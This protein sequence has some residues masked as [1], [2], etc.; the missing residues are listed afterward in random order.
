MKRVRAGLALGLLLA[1]CARVSDDGDLRA[2]A[3]MILAAAEEHPHGVSLADVFGPS[4]TPEPLP[5]SVRVWRRGLDGSRSSCEGRV[6]RLELEEYLRGVLPNEWMAGWEPAALEAGAIAARTYAAFWVAAGGRYTCADVDDTTWTQV[7]RDR[8]DPRTDAAIERTV[9][10]VIVRD[11]SLVMAEYSAENGSPTRY[12]VEDPICQGRRTKGHGRG[13]CQWGTHRWARRGRDAAW[14]V[15]HYYPGARIAWADD[16]LVD[17]VELT[18]TS[19]ERFALELWATNP[20]PEAW[21]PGFLAVRTGPTPFADA[22]WPSPESPAIWE[23]EVPP[24]ETARVRWWMRA[25]EVTEPTLWAEYFWLE[26]PPDRPGTA[27]SWRIT[28]LPDEPA[29]P[30]AA[31]PPEHR[32]RALAATAVVAIALAGGVALAARRSR[33]R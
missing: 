23:A 16:A 8:T 11:G 6:D 30:A 3:L 29:P 24:G 14:M 22:S 25:P 4:D 32:P 10:A 28:V 18:V 21:P 9:G 31:P 7:Y 20:G 1:G 27:G 26:G 15:S 5:T 19:G 13:M 17:G 33:R 2:E 12:G